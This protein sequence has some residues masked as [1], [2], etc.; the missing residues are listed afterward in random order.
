MAR[1]GLALDQMIDQLLVF[2]EATSTTPSTTATTS[3]TSTSTNRT[4]SSP[5]RRCKLT[6]LTEGLN[7]SEYAEL[8]QRGARALTSAG[9]PHAHQPIPHD[10]DDD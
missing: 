3:T 5:I 7:A 8:L 2:D 10:D 4:T 6:S 1:E 9:T